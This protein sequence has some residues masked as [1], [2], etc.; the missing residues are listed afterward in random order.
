MDFERKRVFLSGPMSGCEGYNAKLFKHVEDALVR[1]GAGFV[2]NPARYAPASA[3]HEK[4]HESY[5][6]K[7]IHALTAHVI[8]ADGAERPFYDYMCLLPRWQ[9]SAGARSELAVARVCGIKALEWREDW[10]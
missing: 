10:R 8:G 2:F 1:N 4:P 9:E 5:M 6:L 3:E 7:S